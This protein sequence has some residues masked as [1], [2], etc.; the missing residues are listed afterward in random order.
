M[1]WLMK[2]FSPLETATVF[3]RC[4]PTASKSGA[5]NPSLMG[6]GEK[7]RARRVTSSR[8]SMNRTIESSA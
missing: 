4:A 1:C 6:R 3:F 5:R 7:P 8:P 2:T